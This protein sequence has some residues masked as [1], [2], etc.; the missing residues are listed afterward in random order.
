MAEDNIKDLVVNWGAFG[1]LFVALISFAIIFMANNATIIDSGATTL[2]SY[3]QNMTTTV[4]KVENNSNEVL[5]ILSNTDPEVSDLGSKDSVS[6]SF[7]SAANPKEI[8]ESS[9]PM[10]SYVIADETMATFLLGSLG[11]IFLAVI[12]YLIYKSIRVGA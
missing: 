7:K 9:K 11:A 2:D 12:A 1:I 5:D 8:W 4:E 3:G 6:S 10:F